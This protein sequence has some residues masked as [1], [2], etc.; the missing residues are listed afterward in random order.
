LTD[1]FFPLL[2]FLWEMERVLPFRG[3][4]WINGIAPKEIVPS[5]FR[6]ARFKN[7]S[8]HKELQNNNWIRS[9]QRINSAK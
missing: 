2:E 4:R 3:A 5:L 1:L 6:L 9:I 7:R 8:V